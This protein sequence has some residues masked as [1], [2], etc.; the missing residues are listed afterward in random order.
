MHKEEIICIRRRATASEIRLLHVSI[1]LY[2][3]YFGSNRYLIVGV[4]VLAKSSLSLLFILSK[5][6]FKPEFNTFPIQVNLNQILF[7]RVFCCLYCC[8]PC[9]S[10]DNVKL[11]EYSTGL[12]LRMI[13]SLFRSVLIFQKDV[14]VSSHEVTFSILTVYTGQRCN[15]S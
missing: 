13:T 9:P 6:R 3:P 8:W 4:Y 10:Y 5:F 7:R 15:A 14:H 2:Y 12:M 1:T 11:E